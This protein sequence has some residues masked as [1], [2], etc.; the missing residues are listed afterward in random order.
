MSDRQAIGAVVG[1][2][3]GFVATGFNPLGAAKGAYWGYALG[4]AFTKT[5][6]EA[7]E[8]PRMDDRTFQTSSYG[9]Y[10][11]RVYNT[12]KL[13]GNIFWLEGNQIQETKNTQTV[14]QGGKGGGGTSQVQTTY[15]YS[16]TMAVMLCEGPISGI[17]RIWADNILFYDLSDPNNAGNT[18]N[19][20]DTYGDMEIFLGTESQLPSTTIEQEKGAGNVSAYRGKCYVVFRNFQLEKYGNRI[21]NLQ[22]EVV[23]NALNDASAATLSH[24]TSSGLYSKDM[25]DYPVITPADDISFNFDETTAQV[26]PWHYENGVMHFIRSSKLAYNAMT[27][28]SGTFIDKNS[29]IYGKTITISE[30][31]YNYFVSKSI[32]DFN[33]ILSAE[34]FDSYPWDFDGG[35]SN[36]NEFY[37]RPIDN[38]PNILLAAYRDGNGYDMLAFGVRLSNGRISYTTIEPWTFRVGYTDSGAIQKKLH[39]DINCVQRDGIIYLCRKGGNTFPHH[40]GWLLAFN[41]S[42]IKQT[43]AKSYYNS[44][45]SQLEAFAFRKI[46]PFKAIGPYYFNDGIVSGQNT[47][48]EG[49]GRHNAFGIDP[50]GTSLYVIDID[51]KT[52]QLYDEELNP[53]SSLIDFSGIISSPYS[54]TG[55]R[56]AVRGNYVFISQVKNNINYVRKIKLNHTTNTATYIEELAITDSNFSWGGAFDFSIVDINYSSFCYSVNRYL[57]FYLG[58][59]L[60]TSGIIFTT[61]FLSSTNG[62]TVPQ[63][64]TEELK[65]IDVLTSS[66]YDT[67]GLTADVVKGYKVSNPSPT[68][69]VLKVLQQCFLFD[70]YEEDYKIKFRSRA[71]STSS[72]NIPASDLRAHELGSEAPPQSLQSIKNPNEIPCRV[73][74]N[75]ISQEKDYED[76]FAYADRLSTDRN[77]IS[78]V[79]IPLVLSASDAY[80]IAE[81]LLIDAE[82]EGRGAYEITLPFKYS[83]LER[84]K[85]ITV[86]TDYETLLLRIISIEKGAPGLVKITAVEDSTT[87]YTSSAV[88]SAGT[89]TAQ[90][91]R[92]NPP[93][94]MLFLDLPAL[95][96][97]SNDPGFYWALSPMGDAASWRGA[98]LYKSND[99]GT[100]WDVVDTGLTYAPNGVA[101]NVLSSDVYTIFSYA[102]ELQV[103]FTNGIP[104]TKTEE[105]VRNGA[106]VIAYGRPGNWEI[107]KF[108]TAT[109]ISGNKYALGGL[110][111]GQFGTEWAMSMHQAGDSVVMINKGYIHRAVMS[112]YN[113]NLAQMFLPLTIGSPFTDKYKVGNTGN[114]VAM[115]PHAPSFIRA[116]RNS[117]MDVNISWV[118]RGRYN[119]EWSNSLEPPNTDVD[120]FTVEIMNGLTVVRTLTSVAGNHSVIYTS[121]MQ[122]T[123]W[124]ANKN[125]VDVRIYQQGE[126][127]T[128]GYDATASI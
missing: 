103:A 46:K 82:R 4:S 98:T 37:I 63:V 66:D 65:R 79:D 86:T 3:I 43:L 70:V 85:L 96:A 27:G 110:L 8:G 15:T 120:I 50:Y 34:R 26:L 49:N 14:E 19:S 80:K 25:G 47:Q 115:R 38:S 91:I 123:D 41:V 118:P 107:I 111:R 9:Q 61:P 104:E 64:V 93:T 78:G 94:S 89:I 53:V 23:D 7:A 106:N 55:M 5:Q 116:T 10:I 114:G 20:L 30:M 58:V 74:I 90:T 40:R 71:T 112:E 76:G 2:V 42:E 73:E 109:L 45:T 67:S 21:P 84:G 31:P 117:S 92:T 54:L 113:Y 12:E 83:H 72:A 56:F 100:S 127:I 51:N 32:N 17:R 60:Q 29:S 77:T 97:S 102:Q 36:Y 11:P 81:I 124:G 108:I 22:F 69:S 68:S 128:R 105:Q 95:N 33:T 24:T 13:S 1:G 28:L 57:D 121:A 88:G 87:D 125:P 39:Q 48:Q 44:G 101:I 119:F 122:V 59:G 62:L 52:I 126:L 18:V 16:V 6:L 35:I 75:Y 99:N